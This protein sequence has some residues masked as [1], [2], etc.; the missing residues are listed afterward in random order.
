MAT[1]SRTTLKSYFNTGDRPTEGQFGDLIDSSIH[2]TEDRA[3]TA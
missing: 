2:L 3:T 1:Q